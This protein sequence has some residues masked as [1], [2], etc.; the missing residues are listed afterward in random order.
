[1]RQDIL[2]GRLQREVFTEKSRDNAAGN[3]EI[4]E[5]SEA[6]DLR[7]KAILLAAWRVLRYDGNA[8][9]IV[10]ASG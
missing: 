7:G 9:T 8:R 4:L 6:T 2:F 10:T 1:M 5:E 3:G